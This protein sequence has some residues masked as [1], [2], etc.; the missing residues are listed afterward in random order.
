MEDIELIQPSPNRYLGCFA[1]RE[2]RIVITCRG[3]RTRTIT[4]EDESALC[5]P[6]AFVVACRRQLDKPSVVTIADLELTEA[7]TATSELR[8]ADLPPPV[9]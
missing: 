2:P 7:T 9:V 5:D 4:L 3:E 8:D 1:S 6:N